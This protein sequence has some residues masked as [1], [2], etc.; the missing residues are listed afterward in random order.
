MLCS[1]Y[2]SSFVSPFSLYL[3]LHE[4]QEEMLWGKLSQGG[5]LAR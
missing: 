1:L 4:E 5:L 3:V 2:M